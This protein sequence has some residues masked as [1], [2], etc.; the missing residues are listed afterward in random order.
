MELGMARYKVK[1]RK[2]GAY[3][4]RTSL[5]KK[6]LLSFITAII[7]LGAGEMLM[8]RLYP[9]DP[10][11][12]WSQ[13]HFRVGQL[14]FSELNAIMAPDPELFWR[15]QPNLE[16]RLVTGF[17]G[18]DVLLS[19]MV[20]TDTNGFRIMKGPET[21]DNILFIGDSC[22]FGIGVRASETC[23]ARMS[24][25]LG[26][27]A[28][29]LSCPGYTL[30]QGMVL[31]ERMGWK[32]QPKAL[33]VGFGFNDRLMWDGLTD[34]EQ[35]ALLSTSTSKL[36]DYS[37]LW[38][39][40]ELAFKG[41]L[42]LLKKTDDPARRMPPE[43]FKA[44]AEKLVREAKERNVPVVFFFWPRIEWMSKPDEGHPYAELVKEMADGKSVAVLD[45]AEA[46]RR[47]GGPSLYLDGIHAK[48][49]GHQLAARALAKLMKDMGAF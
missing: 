9:S 4:P 17:V 38:Y 24:E 36:A 32:P 5:K 14:G 15:V 46:F 44:G 23:A 26:V 3:P 48:P 35:A 34:P 8:R 10:E 39:C 33:V 21:S 41:S 45:M 43:L 49:E 6:L 19:F 25:T 40:M 47:N 29:N 18:T 28:R 42:R 31:L 30:Y 27:K 12:R 20:S 37:R 16:D 2:G 11:S 1:N 13:H 7:V 22:T